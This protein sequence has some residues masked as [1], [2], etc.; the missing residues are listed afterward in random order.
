MIRVKC[1]NPACAKDFNL[2]PELA[3]SPLRCSACQQKFVVTGSG[4]VTVVSGGGQAAPAQPVQGAPPPSEPSTPPP[5]RKPE[6]PDPLVGQKLGH[7]RVLEWIGKGAMS[8]VYKGRDLRLDKTVALKVMSP[9]VMAHGREFV[10][11]FIQEAR[12]AA[13]VEHNTVLPVHFIGL[14]GSHIFIAMQYVDGGTLEER[15]VR[16]GRLPQRDALQIIGSVALALWAAHAQNIVHRDIKP[17]NIMLM[18]DGRVLVSDF[19]IAKMGDAPTDLTTA[20]LVMGTPHYMAPEQCQGQKVD[21]RTDLYATGV[22]LYRMV[23]GRLPFKGDSP[24]A[25]VKLH[26]TEPVPDPRALV[27]ELDARISAVIM[28]LLAKKPED[29]FQSAADLVKEMSAILSTPAPPPPDAEPSETAPKR[30]GRLVAFL[31]AA[32][33]LLALGA[34][35]LLFHLSRQS[36]ETEAPV[37]A[38][39]EP[40]DTAPAEPK[41]SATP[42]ASV[43]A[44]ELRPI[45]P[46]LPKPVAP[47][48]PGPAA[49]AAPKPPQTP[50]TQEQAPPPATASHSAAAPAPSPPAFDPAAYMEDVKPVNE[51]ITAGDFSAARSRAN[52]LNEKYPEL[53]AVKLSNIER[54]AALRKR[55]FDSVNSGAAKVMMADVS[56]RYGFA[57]EIKKADDS[58]LAAAIK[59]GW[60]AFTREEIANFYRKASDPKSAD[61]LVGIAAFLVEGN[62]T[63]KDCDQALDILGEA[64][65]LGAAVAPLV[66][67]VEKLR[68]ALRET[69]AEKPKTAE[70]PESAGKG[71]EAPQTGREERPSASASPKSFDDV[72]V[73]TAATGEK[74]PHPRSEKT[75]THTFS[76]KAVKVPEGMVYVPAGP[77]VMGDNDLP[78]AAPAHKKEVE[79]FFIDKYEVTN[80]QYLEFMKAT[81]HAMPE[82]ILNNG[83]QIPKGRENHPVT[84]VS[85]WDAKAYCDWAGKRLPTEAEWEKAASWNPLS[86]RKLRFPWGDQF[87]ENNSNW[88]FRWGWKPPM[89]FK[90]WSANFMESEKGRTL[91]AMGG[92]TMPVGSFK[93]GVSPCGCY[94]MS[95]NVEEWV[96][97]WLEKY[98]GNTSSNERAEG[99]F[100]RR[101]KVMRGDDWAQIRPFPCAQR[102]HAPPRHHNINVGFRCA[103]TP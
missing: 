49:P 72:Y 99:A 63:E 101:V 90:T 54:I 21:G 10:Q 66:A 80:A 94:D 33:I 82:H 55:C 78:L 68:P 86:K 34:F 103:K 17:S 89:D 6:K 50:S 20:G 46:E 14:E 13:K 102:G 95:G 75:R 16:E 31:A 83:G 36:A 35:A 1:P 57:G 96:A 85:W 42:P 91:I 7:Y 41:A 32:G 48:V 30:K 51:R 97:D 22:T 28:R 12:T 65:G 100:E 44:T 8:T 19:G 2:N 25:A 9:A 56:K 52:L 38:M 27:P 60:D 37:P 59:K 61:D 88:A 53:I 81:G 43:P 62:A 5:A 18:R 70:P 71:R 23:T 45:V 47:E 64:K 29:R 77:F 58:G 74:I 84:Q 39:P 3:G 93:K 76:G 98:E 87:D 26:L 24:E 67:Y 4:Q 40:V 79:G 92:A 11:Q 69:P 15:I 73:A